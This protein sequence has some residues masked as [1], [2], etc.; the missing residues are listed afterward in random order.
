YFMNKRT[1]LKQLFKPLT[2]NVITRQLFTLLIVIFVASYAVI[3]TAKTV[4]GIDLEAVMKQMR[5][6]FN[7]AMKT[8]SAATMTLHIQAFK[9]QL[10]K[11]KQFPFSK[12]RIEKATEGLGKVT[13][14]IEQITLPITA[15][16]LDQ[17]KQ[18]LAAIDDIKEQY[19]DKKVSLWDRFY[20]QLFGENEDNAKLIL[21]E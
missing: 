17:S 11:A 18:L 5:F 15:Q 19:H 21:L 20:E 6:E 4:D 9:Q 12:E 3:G 16:S 13:N 8:D 7:Q 10:S 1:P 14:K 2:S